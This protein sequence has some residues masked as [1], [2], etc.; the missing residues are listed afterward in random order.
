[1]CRA[2]GEPV[3]AGGAVILCFGG[4][5]SGTVELPPPSYCRRAECRA[6]RDAAAIRRAVAAGVIR[7]VGRIGR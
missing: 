1:M 6:D 7:P 2:C 4:G 3:E 5:E